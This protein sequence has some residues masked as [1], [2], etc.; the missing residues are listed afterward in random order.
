M[1]HKLLPQSPACIIFGKCFSEIRSK[2]LREDN[3][4]FFDNVGHYFMELIESS[5]YKSEAGFTFISN[6]ILRQDIF[7]KIY[8]FGNGKHLGAPKTNLT[9][10]SQLCRLECSV[11]QEINGAIIAV[12]ADLVRA[13]FKTIGGHSAVLKASYTRLLNGQEVLGSSYFRIRIFLDTWLGISPNIFKISRY[14]GHAALWFYRH[15]E[16]YAKI[17][18]ASI[19]QAD[20]EY[21]GYW[22]YH[23]FSAYLERLS[24]VAAS[25]MLLDLRRHVA[26][27]RS[28]PVIFSEYSLGCDGLF[29][30][31]NGLIKG[32]SK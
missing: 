8:E 21:Y 7:A 11:N 6:T 23:L 18:A 5:I 20:G 19:C 27:K 25:D 3:T 1:I 4:Y 29:C 31:V 10:L 30:P 17:I 28:Y 24:K 2:K 22:E 32:L 12:E 15:L 9:V 13:A 26:S 16:Y 14:H